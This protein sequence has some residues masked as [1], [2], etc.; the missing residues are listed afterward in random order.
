VALA[1]IESAVDMMMGDKTKLKT[2]MTD[3]RDGDFSQ[4]SRLLL[5]Y[6]RVEFGRKFRHPL[7]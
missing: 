3:T 5:L 2:S 4:I 1:K 7:G 6:F